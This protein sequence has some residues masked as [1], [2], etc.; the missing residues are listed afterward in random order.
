MAE[1]DGLAEFKFHGWHF[2]ACM[3]VSVFL[4]TMTLSSGNDEDNHDD[5]EGLGNES[6]YVTEYGKSFHS[7]E[8]VHL[9]GRAYKKVT[10]EWAV[11]HRYQPCRE[12]EAPLSW[13]WD[14]E[15]NKQVVPDAWYLRLL[16]GSLIVVVA[17]IF[18]GGAWA[19]RACYRYILGQIKDAAQ[20]GSGERSSRDGQTIPWARLFEAGFAGFAVLAALV[21][22]ASVFLTKDSGGILGCVQ[23]SSPW[24]CYGNLLCALLKRTLLFSFLSIGFL[25]TFPPLVLAAIRRDQAR[26]RRVGN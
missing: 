23:D 20:I 15:A 12:C 4:S 14:Y 11:E 17:A 10:V 5:Y 7:G 21:Q 13:D 26:C 6:V 9:S 16:W 2:A 18:V 1:A 24:P 8:C 22:F 19:V 3:A 25:L